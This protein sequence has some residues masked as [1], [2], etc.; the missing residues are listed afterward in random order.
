MKKQ[1]TLADAMQRATSEPKT[2]SRVAPSRRGKKAVVLYVEPEL[3]KR[4]KVLAAENE[5]TIHALGLK[6]LD[7][8]FEQLEV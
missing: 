5:T 7:L 2:T 6:A 4:L 3:A 1:T 8:L